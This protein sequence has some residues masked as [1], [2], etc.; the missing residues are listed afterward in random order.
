MGMCIG[1]PSSKSFN[2][3]LGSCAHNLYTQSSNIYDI[4]LAGI[5]YLFNGGLSTLALCVGYGEELDV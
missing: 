3:K 5:T 2:K 1:T 4:M